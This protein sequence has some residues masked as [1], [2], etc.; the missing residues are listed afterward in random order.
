MGRLN[1]A[2][3]MVYGGTSKVLSSINLSRAESN[4]ISVVEELRTVLDTNR[5]LMEKQKRQ[6]GTEKRCEKELRE[7]SRWRGMDDVEKAAARV[8]VKGPELRFINTCN[9]NFSLEGASKE[10]RT[11]NKS[12]QSQLRDTAED[13]QAAGELLVRLK[14]AEE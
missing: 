3:I 13:V 2:G 9:R 12:L 10:R 11:E 14:E 5:M 4:W 8:G 1:R 6:L 7:A